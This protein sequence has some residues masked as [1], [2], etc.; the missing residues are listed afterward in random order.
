MRQTSGAFR[1]FEPLITEL[2]RLTHSNEHRSNDTLRRALKIDS[3]WSAFTP[4]EFRATKIVE[5][6]LIAV[7]LFAMFAPL[8]LPG[9]AGILA[10]FLLFLY[11]VVARQSLVR[12]F[13]QRLN[14]QRSRLPFVVDQI[15]LTMQAGGNFEESLTAI[16]DEE[17]DHPLASELAMVIHD[18]NAGR[19]RREALLDF[20]DRVPD[21]D[22]GEFIFAVTKGEELGTP[23]GKILLE[24]SEQ[25]R[26]KRAL[27]GEKAAAEAEVQIVFPG[28]LVMIACL[29]VVLGPI[30]LPA[31]LSLFS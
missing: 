8:G 20:R 24:Q 26:V 28:M 1:W 16:V 23:L 9:F 19:S 27:W 30:L 15:A 6:S 21:D 13:T 7:S 25:M 4:R 12:T 2:I 3:R 14:R 31:I 18:V 10:V 11:P 29:I 5:S 22:V 17:P